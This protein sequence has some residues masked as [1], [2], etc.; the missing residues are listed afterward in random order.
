MYEINRNHQ[1]HYPVVEHD[2]LG[3]RHSWNLLQ[4]KENQ[5]KLDRENNLGRNVNKHRQEG[6]I[7]STTEC[8]VHQIAKG[9]N[10]LLA[11]K[12]S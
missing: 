10:N 8:D 7:Q 9:E 4:G 5:E 2:I 12:P 11:L 1:S 3:H 6:N